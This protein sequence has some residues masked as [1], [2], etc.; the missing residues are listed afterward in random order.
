MRSTVLAVIGGDDARA[1]AV[2]VVAAG[3][4][5]AGA[6]ACLRAPLTIGAGTALALAVGLSVQVL[7]WPR[8]PAIVVGSVL[9]AV[10]MVRWERYP[11]AGFG[12]RLADLR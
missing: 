7:P 12:V 6:R 5:V 9:L 10:G 2:L 4:M 11:I 1:V 3:A 8:A